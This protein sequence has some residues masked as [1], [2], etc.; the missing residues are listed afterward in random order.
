M[1][2]LSM[3][4]LTATR[5]QS[6]GEEVANCI[7]HGIAALVAIVLGPAFVF[8][9][10]HQGDA[11]RTLGTGIFV[12]AAVSLYLTSTLYHAVPDGRA[13]RVFQ[14]LDHCTIYVMIAGT[15]T[16]FM[17]AGRPD[18][19]DF[20]LLALV[21]GVATTGIAVKA[22][23]GARWPRT[24]TA[25]FLL[26]GWLSVFALLERF[27]VMPTSGV[28]WTVTGGVAYTL[29]VAFFAVDGIRYTHFVWHLFVIAGTSSHAVV[30][31]RYLS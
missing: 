13:K 20:A 2:T 9:V 3:R 17:L 31:W 16:P 14:I 24:S 29:G 25:C 1:T 4:S 30:V 27:M 26:L 28:V 22:I 6:L 18:A 12:A 15:Y 21:W 7:S 10:G 19:R 23:W 11:L 8:V 5:P